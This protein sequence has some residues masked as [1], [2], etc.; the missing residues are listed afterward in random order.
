MGRGIESAAGRHDLFPAACSRPL[1]LDLFMRGSEA[2]ISAQAPRPCR[3]S[4]DR[5][6]ASVA[7][8]LGACRCERMPLDHWKQ[9]D[10]WLTEALLIATDGSLSSQHAVD[11]GVRLARERGA[12]VAFVHSSPTISATLFERN[13]YTL[14]TAEEIASIDPTLRSSL[15]RAQEAG[16]DAELTVLSEHGASSVAAAIVGTAQS[17]GATM[18]VVG[19]RGRGVMTEAMVGSVSRTVMKMSDV[20]VIVVHM[21]ESA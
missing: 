6:R 10:S 8:A 19:A 3:A 4:L 9:E 20:P 13:P 21:H 7:V 16:V 11:V 18:I 12:R 1:L 2:I 15:E 14:D 17:L 5:K